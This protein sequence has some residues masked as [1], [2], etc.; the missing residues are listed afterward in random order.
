MPWP[1]GKKMNPETKA[2]MAEARKGKPPYVRTE[3]FKAR[4]SALQ[5]GRELSEATKLKLALFNQ[6]PLS[7]FLS[8]TVS[9]QSIK[10]RLIREG[11]LKE[12]C[13]K[14]G[15]KSEWLG[16][17]LTL[18]LDHI[19]GSDKNHSIDNLRLMC[20]NCHSQTPTWAGRNKWKVPISE[21]I[22]KKLSETS[23]KRWESTR[24]NKCL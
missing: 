7:E 20:P 16:E 3:E 4:M 1:K 2:K 5:K 21:E 12:E 24:D 13:Y 9:N 8:S 18:Q 17:P 11:I 6:R 22:R 19:D 23:I 15:M 14:C 10:R